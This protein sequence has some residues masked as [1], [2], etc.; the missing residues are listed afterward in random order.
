MEACSYLGKARVLTEMPWLCNAV[1]DELPVVYRAA[2]KEQHGCICY[3]VLF[4]QLG[5]LAGAVA[6][7]L[8]AESRKGMG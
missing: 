6:A 5:L 1:F 4:A 8:L 2:G 3:V 7:W